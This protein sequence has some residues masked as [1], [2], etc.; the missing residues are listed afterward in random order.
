MYNDLSVL[1]LNLMMLEKLEAKNPPMSRCHHTATMFGSLM[2]IFGGCKI[3]N[4][5][6]EV[7]NDMYYIDISNHE[8][9][10]WVKIE[11][12][13]KIPKPRYGHLALK[14][15]YNLLI[16]GGKYIEGK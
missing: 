2:F 11:P 16:H 12:K 5:F 9:L 15:G 4:Y 1:H 13:G 3:E 14:I 8:A 6:K 10:E 7:F